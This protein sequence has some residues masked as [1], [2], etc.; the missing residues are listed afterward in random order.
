MCLVCTG[1]REALL[2]SGSGGNGWFLFGAEME[3]RC[4]KNEGMLLKV[5]VRFRWGK[6][7]ALASEYM[8]VLVFLLVFI[9]LLLI[10]V[11][12]CSKVAVRRRYGK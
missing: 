8:V 12:G 10:F 3:S 5:K 11:Y 2:G 4:Y 9:C 6:G 1:A 7:A